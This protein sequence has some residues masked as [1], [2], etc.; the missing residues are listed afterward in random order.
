[1]KKTCDAAFKAKVALEAVRQVLQI[2]KPEIF[3]IDQGPQST[4]VDFT[5]LLENA[6]P[7]NCPDNGVHVL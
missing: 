4:S 2:S 6:R 5:D 7:L 3:N 1:M